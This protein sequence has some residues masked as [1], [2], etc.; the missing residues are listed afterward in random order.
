MIFR[1][2]RSRRQL[3]HLQQ[4]SRVIEAENESL[5]S[6]AAHLRQCRAALARHLAEQEE[7][8]VALNDC[9]IRLRSIHAQQK[10]EG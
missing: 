9:V 3:A 7:C 1:W 6:E 2:L 5:R 4:V 10:G 8:L